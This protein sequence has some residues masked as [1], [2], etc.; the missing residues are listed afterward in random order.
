MKAAL[1]I[2]FLSIFHSSGSSRPD[3]IYSCNDGIVNFVSN[4]PLEVIR[5]R[6]EQLNGA[7]DAERKTFL[8]SVKVSSFHGFNS[9]LQREHFNENYLETAKFPKAT[10]EGKFIEDIDFTKEGVYEIRAKG[11]L[12]L[13]G[14][15][16]ERILKGTVKINP[17]GVQLS[18]QFPILLEDHGIKIPRV[19]YQKISPEIEVSINTT[20]K[21]LQGKGD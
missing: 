12:D 4:A 8:F 15:R 1:L 16:Q 11:I 20:M 17:A 9:G 18:A 2:L 3:R 6:S 21:L 7:I 19:V 14:I 13:H 10:F 5:A